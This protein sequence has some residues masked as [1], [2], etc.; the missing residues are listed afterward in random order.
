MELRVLA[1]RWFPHETEITDELLGQVIFLEQREMEKL[2][3][4]VNNGIAMAFNH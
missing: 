1:K 2:Q 4:A 3:T